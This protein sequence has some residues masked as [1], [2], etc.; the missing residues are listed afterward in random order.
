[1]KCSWAVSYYSIETNVK[2]SEAQA[3]HYYNQ[4]LILKQ[5]IVQTV[6]N[7]ANRFLKL[8]SKIDPNN[9]ILVAH[10]ILKFVQGLL[11]QLITI[12]YASNP[13]DV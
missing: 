13:E 7:Y 10:I 6:D 12:T 11:S 2:R 9:N 8:R 4:Y 3:T 1:M 5:E